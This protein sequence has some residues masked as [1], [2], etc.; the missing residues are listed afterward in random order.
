MSNHKCHLT[1][2]HRWLERKIL[3]NSLR[4]KSPVPSYE[5]KELACRTGFNFIKLKIHY[6]HKRIKEC[7]LQKD[8]LL[9]TLSHSLSEDELNTIQDY[10]KAQGE[11]L[12]A[13]KLLKYDTMLSSLEN[14]NSPQQK[15]NSNLSNK[16]VFNLSHKTLTED[17]VQVLG[18]GL[19]FAIAPKEVP[20][21]NILPSVEDGLRGIPPSE[22]DL[23]RGKVVSTIQNKKR[24]RSVLTKKEHLALQQLQKDPSIIITKADKGNITTVLDKE[25][26]DNKINK[27]LDDEETYTRLKTNPTASTSKDVNK[28]INN[29]LESN[30]ITKEAS[31]RL[32]ISDAT[33]PRLYG[34]PILHTENIPLRPI[35]SFTDS[36]A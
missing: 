18:L 26:Y 34:L 10:E 11:S 7:S 14:T 24:Q 9:K 20:T 32:K 4:I 2:L 22:A 17:Q 3:P 1:F 19:N 27:M 25:W 30:K 28:F 13:K 33:I 36:P 6:S 15:K 12:C 5:G 16:W 8:N 31:F 35:V 29:L 23:I 21:K